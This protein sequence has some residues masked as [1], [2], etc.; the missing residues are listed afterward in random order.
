M[1]GARHID[2]DSI[3][4][5]NTEVAWGVCDTIIHK[6]DLARFLWE[7]T[8]IEL[9]TGTKGMCEKSEVPK[10]RMPSL[11]RIGLALSAGP[12]EGILMQIRSFEIPAFSNSR[13]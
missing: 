5:L 2:F 9:I 1:H 12:V 11:R 10:V 6:P 4:Q 8:T 7:Y 13:A 3:T